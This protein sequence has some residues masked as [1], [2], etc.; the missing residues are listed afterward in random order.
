MG[1]D[2]EGGKEVS[3]YLCCSP[4][5]A[6]SVTPAAIFYDGGHCIPS[7]H[8]TGTGHSIIQYSA[9]AI[10]TSQTSLGLK[11]Q[12]PPQSQLLG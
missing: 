4:S 10:H 7:I 2:G 1:W 12:Q 8:E 9:A 5:L 6:P 3:F 11:V